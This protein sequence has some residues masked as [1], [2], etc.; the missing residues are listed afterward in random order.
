MVRL[1]AILI[2]LATVLIAQDAYNGPNPPKPNIPYIVHADNLVETESKT[3]HEQTTKNATVYT[4]DGEKSTART[5]LASPTLVID[6][7]TV[8]AEKLALFRF[9]V[10]N[11]HREVTLRKDGKGGSIPLHIETTKVSGRLY[12]IRI[13]DSLDNGEYGLSPDGSNDAFCFEVF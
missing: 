12:Q 9:D 7:T 10:K 8:D 13:L 4:I 6:A 1:L 5:P 2:T 3:A 11:G